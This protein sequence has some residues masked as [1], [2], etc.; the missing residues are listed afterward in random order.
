M[1]NLRKK[2]PIHRSTHVYQ[3]WTCVSLADGN[4]QSVFITI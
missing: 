3:L 2:E 1:T 4:E